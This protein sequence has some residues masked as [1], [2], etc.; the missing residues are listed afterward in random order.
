MSCVEYSYN[1]NP[2]ACPEL[3]IMP[4]S[5]RENVDLKAVVEKNTWYAITTTDRICSF[6]DKVKRSRPKEAHWYN[7]A[8]IT[9]LY[10]VHQRPVK[11]TADQVITG[12]GQE[13]D[14]NVMIFT[15]VYMH[16]VVL[17]SCGTVISHTNGMNQSLFHQQTFSVIIL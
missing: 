11:E 15:D 12:I 13:L 2:K 14:G 5:F 7:Q 3:V 10:L 16:L 4:D 9:H 8:K 1:N 17:F 6:C